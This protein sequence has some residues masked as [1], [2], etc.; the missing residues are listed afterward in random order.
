MFPAVVLAS[1]L[2]H[3]WGHAWMARAFGQEVLG[4]RLHGFGGATYHRGRLTP[5]G[6][7]C[8]SLAGPFAGFV[9]SFPLWFV[10]VPEGSIFFTALKWQLLWVNV[11][12]GLINLFPALPLDGGQAVEGV[13]ALFM[14]PDKARSAA[15]YLGATA[16]MAVVGVSLLLGLSSFLMLMGGYCAYISYQSARP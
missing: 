5:V 11:G 14:K 12:W 6:R 4:I 7:I 8:I 9:A 16:G 1:V 3:E 15:G 2:L 13:F 10:P